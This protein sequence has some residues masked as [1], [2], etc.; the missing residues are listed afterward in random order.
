MYNK[1]CLLNT[2]QNDTVRIIHSSL[3]RTCLLRLGSAD[4]QIM[5]KFSLHI[6]ALVFVMFVCVC[7]STNRVKIHV[8]NCLSN[9]NY[10]VP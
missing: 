3:L 7:C 2:V 1:Q 4:W 9:E 5:E 10:S 6:K 8:E